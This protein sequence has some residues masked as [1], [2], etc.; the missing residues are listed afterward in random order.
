ME[1][2]FPAILSFASSEDKYDSELVYPILE[3]NRSEEE[4]GHIEDMK[5]FNGYKW[6]L[7]MLLGSYAGKDSPTGNYILEHT[8]EEIEELEQFDK[9]KMTYLDCFDVPRLDSVP[10]RVGISPLNSLCSAS[11]N[12]YEKEIRHSSDPPTPPI[13]IKPC[14]EAYSNPTWIQRFSNYAWKA[15]YIIIF[16]TSGWVDSPWTFFELLL[17]KELLTIQSD[18]QFIIITGWSLSY[19]EGDYIEMIIDF[20]T[21]INN[22][23]IIDL[24]IDLEK[25]NLI[26]DYKNILSYIK[27]KS[28]F[29]TDEMPSDLIGR[30]LRDY[31]SRKS[32]MK[33][34]TRSDFISLRIYKCMKY[35]LRGGYKK[36]KR[37]SKRKK[38]RRKKTKRKKKKNTK[39]R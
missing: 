38:T 17:Y 2:S 20:M 25:D 26:N 4:I 10:Y 33:V 39:K 23:S 5:T 3:C 24:E 30:V 13:R 36:S 15:R 21:T 32:E 35:I 7:I 22:L 29:T 34:L 12:G 28:P 18:K 16:L 19:L 6:K 11:Y 31:K 37:K 9:T 27:D 8:P 1:D 14:C